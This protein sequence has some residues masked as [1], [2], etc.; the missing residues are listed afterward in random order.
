[1]LLQEV[2]NRESIRLFH[3]VPFRLY[4][5]DP[6]WIPALKQ[7]VEK[8]FDTEKNKLF[9]EGG[10]SI[11]WLLLDDKGQLL[12]RLAAFVNPRAL[13]AGQMQA[14]GI[15]FFDCIDDFG[16]ATMLLDAGRDWLKQQG[17]EAMD[18]PV[19]FGDRQQFWGCQVSNW[20]ESPIYPM[21]Y[22]PPYAHKLFERYGFGIYFRQFVFH[23]R[24][25]IPAQPVF[26]RKVAQLQ[27]SGLVVK[28]IRGVSLEKVAED[29][30]KVYNGGWGGHAHFK[31]LSSEAAQKIMKAM[32]PAI[33]PE[34]II[35]VYD[36]EEPV[37]FYVNLP[38]LNEIFCHVNGDMNLMG[39]LKFLY[40]KM[41][42]TPRRMTGIVFGVVR[43]WQGKGLEAL[44]IVYGEQTIAKRGQYKDTVLSW[45]GDFNPKML[46]VAENLGATVWREFHT[47]RYQF[48]RNRPFERAPITE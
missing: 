15:G 8:L 2:N 32:K 44:M 42:K 10:K 38:E 4:G 26:Y 25:D 21:N 5:D 43:E 29:F 46:R 28:D 36:K 18:G 24:V 1:M 27:D 19:N 6:K 47:Y 31:E 40:H 17:M 30:R 45:I 7:D 20:D 33:D 34:I 37:A 12:G 13:I 22:N 23:R 39:K 48:D 41:R 16:A 11:R 35:F 14:G 9:K 3:E